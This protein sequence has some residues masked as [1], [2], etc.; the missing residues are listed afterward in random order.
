M[1]AVELRKSL[2]RIYAR[3]TAAAADEVPPSPAGSATK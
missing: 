1:P 3:T 2:E